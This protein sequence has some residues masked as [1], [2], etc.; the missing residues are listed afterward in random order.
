MIDWKTVEQQAVKMLSEYLRIPTVNPPGDMAA[1]VDFLKR[2]L[3]E[4]GISTQTFE[5]GPGRITLLARLPG[6]GQKKPILLYNHMDVVE[7]DEQHWSRN[8]F[9]GEVEDGY[10]Y[11]RGA[12]DMKGMGIMQLLAMDLLQHNHP[13]RSR[14]I[15]FFAAPDEETG[16]EFGTRWMVNNHWEQMDP[17]FV[18]DEGGFGL[19]EMFGPSPVFTVALAEK[20][21]LWLKFRANG[22]PGQS[23]M[24]HEGN[25]VNILMNALQRIMKAG[26]KW[27]VTPL[28]NRMFRKIAET[29][30]FPRSFLLGNL[31]N[32]LVFNLVKN[33]LTSEKTIGAMLRNTISITSFHAGD[34]ENIIPETA[35]ATLDVRLLP[36]TDPEKFLADITDLVKDDRINISVILAPEQASVSDMNTDFYRSLERVMSRRVSGSVTAPMLTPGTTDSC[37]FR[38]KGVNCYG[39]FP[40]IINPGELSRFHGNDERISI[41]NLV[42]GVQIIYDVLEELTC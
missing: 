39:L 41:K 2:Q 40:A 15:L 20:K 4:R 23:G 36:H 13:D 28:T 16:G 31:Q 14:D 25:A 26:S 27:E 9:G 37:F 12:I 3:R 24:P 18:W 7:V 5:S 42:L 30:P 10:V 33:Q 22:A 11:G 6:S 19:Q 8:P 34:K 21:T 35:E 38:Q 1:A 29:M 17:E 32:P